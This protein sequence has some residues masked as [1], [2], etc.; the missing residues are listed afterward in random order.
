[1]SHFV[2]GLMVLFLSLSS[3]AH[4]ETDTGLALSVK[5]LRNTN[6]YLL[7]AIFDDARAFPDHPEG[8]VQTIREKVTARSMRV[9]FNDLAPGTYAVSLV[10]DENGNGKLDTGSFGRPIEGF[11]FSK[12]PAIRFSAPTFE[13][14]KFEINRGSNSIEILPNYM[15]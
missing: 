7:V 5:N 15:R 14:T 8:A 3:F 11:G 12:N 1:M 4:A 13:E 2:S 6:G 10:H 9:K